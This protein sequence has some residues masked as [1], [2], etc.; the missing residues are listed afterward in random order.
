MG[1]NTRGI[2]NISLEWSFTDFL[3][4]LKEPIKHNVL[5]LGSHKSENDFM[6]LQSALKLLG[7]NG[8]L[9]K[10]SPDL[11]IQSNL[12]KLYAAIIC[13]S[14]IIVVDKEASGHIAELSHLLS[15]RFR[16]V[17]ILRNESYP[18]TSFLEDKL[19]TDD[20]FK[21][22]IISDISA[23]RLLPYIQ[24]AKE[25]IEKQ[26]VNFNKINYWRE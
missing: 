16:P 23:D 24:W 13:S 18:S 14:F 3:K 8:F 6:K 5:L 1:Q 25:K 4:T 11:P 19:L 2:K 7:Y 17:I 15:I 22:A 21:I 10:D 9:L 26:I 20:Y 12:E